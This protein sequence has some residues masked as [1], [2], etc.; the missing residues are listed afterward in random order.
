M[1]ETSQKELSA[2]FNSQQY[3]KMLREKGDD[4]QNW[5]WQARQR[6]KQEAKERKMNA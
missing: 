1:M 5:N 6:T 2:L 4:I 3:K